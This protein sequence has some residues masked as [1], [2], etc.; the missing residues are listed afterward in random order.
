MTALCCS[1]A[2]SSSQERLDSP[3]HASSS[4][5]FDRACTAEYAVS[6]DLQ[7][8]SACLATE[9]PFALNSDQLAA[10]ADV[11]SPLQWHSSSPLA[12]LS[13]TQHHRSLGQHTHFRSSTARSFLSSSRAAAFG[14]HQQSRGY[15][16]G[17]VPRFTGKKLKPYSSYRERFK[18]MANGKIK[19][20]HPGHR[21]KRHPK[22]GRQNLLLKGS[23][24]VFPAVANKMKRIGFT[25]R[26]FA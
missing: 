2:S 21:H 5:T 10:A 4:S 9:L 16:S 22:S 19:R 26:A 7:H 13:M 20:M 6:L 14:Q 12:A 15:A 1:A 24:V 23:A 11:C 17:P 8:S 3:R 18:L 25:R